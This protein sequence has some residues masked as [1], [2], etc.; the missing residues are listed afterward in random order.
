MGSTNSCMQYACKSK[1]KEEAKNLWLGGYASRRPIL[2]RYL[3]LCSS[4][5]GFLAAQSFI[6][7]TSHWGFG[8]NTRKL[9]DTTTSFLIKK[10]VRVSE[11]SGNFNYVSLVYNFGAAVHWTGFGHVACPVPG[12]GCHVPNIPASS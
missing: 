10:L 11:L 12:F 2:K 6:L 8:S 9:T 7:I 3:F 1:K 5:T 4:C